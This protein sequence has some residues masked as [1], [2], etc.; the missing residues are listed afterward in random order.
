[1]RRSARTGSAEQPFEVETEWERVIQGAPAKEEGEMGRELR[2]ARKIEGS[3]EMSV[4]M[5]SAEE[6]IERVQ[7]EPE[8]PRQCQMERAREKME[9]PGDWEL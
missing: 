3:V 8:I 6:K 1:M 9:R 4:A 5:E 7:L 2:F